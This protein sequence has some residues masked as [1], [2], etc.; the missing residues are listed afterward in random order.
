M[1]YFEHV[2]LLTTP[3]VIED[4]ALLVQDGQ[5]AALGLAGTVPKPPEAQVVPADGLFL[6]AGYID[7]Q[8]NGGF[9]E[10]FTATPESIYS[11]AAQL[12]RFGVTAFLPTII[13]SPPGTTQ[14]AL[15]VWRQGAPQGWRGAI[16]LGLHLEGPM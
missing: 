6:A 8:I 13:T 2:T 9:G 11:V 5:I 12:P 14:A 10:D 15:E 7:L 3:Q 16:P 4:G 1:L